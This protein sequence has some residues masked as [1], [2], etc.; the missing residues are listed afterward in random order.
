MTHTNTA[1]GPLA[2]SVVDYILRITYEIWEQRG[3]DRI[4]DY[5][6]ADGPIYALAG[7][8]RGAEVV[9][10]GTRAMLDAFPDR[11]LVGDD[12]VWSGTLTAGYSSHRIISTMTHR[13]DGPLGPPTGRQARIL[14]IADCLIEDGIIV[15]EW[16]FRDQVS[17]VRQLGLDPVVVATTVRRGQTNETRDWLAAERARLH[18]G[19]EHVDHPDTAWIVDTLH[20]LLVT[21]D[22]DKV[23]TSHAEFAALHAAGDDLKSGREPLERHYADLRRAFQLDHLSVD[24]VMTLDERADGQ[25]VAVRWTAC[26]EHVGDYLGLP[27]TGRPVLIGGSTHWRRWNGRIIVEWTVFDGVGVLAQLVDPA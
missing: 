27:A 10:D 11:I 13:G 24:H 7:V 5:Y 22:R 23:A 21:G 3:I 14:T 20:A 9:V 17:L 18:A 12:V 2:E 6:S 8:T 4:R 15:R 26:G 19:G 16:L 25:T 1:P